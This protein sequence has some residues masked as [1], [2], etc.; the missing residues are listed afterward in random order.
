M[1]RGVGGCE[2]YVARIERYEISIT[3]LSERLNK[4]VHSG[5][6]KRRWENDIKNQC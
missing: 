6:P 4:R 5:K 3:F 1:G 2:R